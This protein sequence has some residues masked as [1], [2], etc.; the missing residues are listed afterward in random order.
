MIWTMYTDAET[1]SIVIY[2]P[3]GLHIFLSVKIKVSLNFNSHIKR[4]KCVLYKPE[5]NIESNGVFTSC[6]LKSVG[7]LM[8]ILTSF[9]NGGNGL[10]V[11]EVILVQCYL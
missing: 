1:K 7:S 4:F 11:K 5:I 3:I 2:S 8:L 9:N 6:F 10:F